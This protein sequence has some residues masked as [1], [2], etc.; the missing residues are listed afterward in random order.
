MLWYLGKPAAS[1]P[2]AFK[3]KSWILTKEKKKPEYPKK[4]EKA[5]EWSGAPAKSKESNPHEQLLCPHCANKVS[6]CYAQ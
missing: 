4:N 5:L 3:I 2:T 6:R 1:L